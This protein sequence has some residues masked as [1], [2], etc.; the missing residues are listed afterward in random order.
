MQNG[1]RQV[2]LAAWGTVVIVREFETRPIRHRQ[3]EGGQRKTMNKSATYNRRIIETDGDPGYETEMC[4][5]K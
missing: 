4:D 5:H 1:P 2:V 3:G